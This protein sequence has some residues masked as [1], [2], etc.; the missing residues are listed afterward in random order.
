MFNRLGISKQTF[1][2]ITLLFISTRFF[3]TVVG[4]VSKAVPFNKPVNWYHSDNKLL[5]VWGNWDSAWYLNIAEFGYDARK[6][7]Y[8]DTYNQV[9]YNFF[10]AYPLAIKYLTKFTSSYYHHLV[11]EYHRDYF[12]K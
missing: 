7:T 9:S 2:Y 10:P 6:S 5:D 8:P 3:L 11:K 1:I 4:V 12:N